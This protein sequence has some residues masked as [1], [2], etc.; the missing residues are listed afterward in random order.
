MF[1][2][3]ENQSS[4]RCRQTTCTNFGRRDKSLRQIFASP[5]FL[6]TASSAN[7]ISIYDMFEFRELQQS[8]GLPI[9][10]LFNCSAI[11]AVFINPASHTARDCLS[12][13]PLFQHAHFAYLHNRLVTTILV[14]IFW[15]KRANNIK[16]WSTNEN[17]DS[18]R[19]VA[20]F[21]FFETRKVSRE[22]GAKL[23][24]K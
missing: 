4:R 14:C 19:D 18:R 15:K 11:I 23:D 7:Q 5:L 9:S 10:V 20:L 8:R 21:Y 2:I 24:S 22:L 12:L 6:R 1:P 13:L 3:I 17:N 16:I